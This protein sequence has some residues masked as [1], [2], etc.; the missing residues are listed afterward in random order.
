ME[1]K[2]ALLSSKLIESFKT[3]PLWM[4]YFTALVD[5]IDLDL[6]KRLT[7]NYFPESI[8]VPQSYI[9]NISGRYRI[10]PTLPKTTLKFNNNNKF[11]YKGKVSSIIQYTG[12]NIFVIGDIND[13]EIFLEDGFSPDGYD[14]Y[15]DYLEFLHFDPKSYKALCEAAYLLNSQIRFVNHEGSLTVVLDGGHADKSNNVPVVD[16]G[17]ADAEIF[18]EVY[19]GGNANTIYNLGEATSVTYQLRDFIIL[20]DKTIF[21]TGYYDITVGDRVF[22]IATSKIKVIGVDHGLISLESSISSSAKEIFVERFT[23]NDY[24]HNVYPK[25]IEINT[26]SS[27]FREVVNNIIPSYKTI[28]VIG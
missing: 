19:D 27:K 24:D 4:Q 9:E 26:V 18:E 1:I 6:L 25:Y 14:V 13:V 5:L 7:Q 17:T 15:S 16:G 8:K 23:S 28:N 10:V 22:A 11:D 12:G 21:C 20:N 2:S 3:S